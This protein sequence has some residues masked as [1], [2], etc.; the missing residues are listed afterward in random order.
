MTLISQPFS[1]AKTI[2]AGVGVLLGVSLFSSFFWGICM[3]WG[4]QVAKDVVSSHDKILH[5]FERI[6]F[7]LQRLNIYTGIPLTNELTALLGK[8]MA[9]LLRIIALSTKAMTESRISELIHS[10]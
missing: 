5:I 10:L 1:P 2:F 7:F 8:I 9:Q 6:Y 3:I 4:Y